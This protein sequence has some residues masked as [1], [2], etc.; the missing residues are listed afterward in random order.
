MRVK[1]MRPARWPSRPRGAAILAAMLVT[2][3]VATLA[4]G[5][6]AQINQ[7][8][9]RSESARNLAQAQSLANVAIN[10]AAQYLSEESRLGP[11]DHLGELWATGLPPTPVEGGTLGGAIRDAQARYN[12]NNVR[13]DQGDWLEHELAFARALAQRVHVPTAQLDA[14]LALRRTRLLTAFDIPEALQ[15]VMTALPERTAINVNTAPEPVL[16][17]L[18]PN[19]PPR[20]WAQRAVQ[21]FLD[22]QAFLTA[23]AHDGN[24]ITPKVALSVGTRYF[25]VDSVAAFGNERAGARA[26]V[27]RQRGVVWRIAR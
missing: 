3:T 12:L 24:R 17:T 6:L 7:W 4:T 13:N 8:F 25:E 2:A 27:E 22:T 21:P 18:A 20:A 5:M 10:W 23:I 15:E 14:V 9:S 11:I 26:L 1:R 16:A 19:A